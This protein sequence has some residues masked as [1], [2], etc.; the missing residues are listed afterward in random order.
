MRKRGRNVRSAVSTFA[1]AAGFAALLLLFAKA[2]RVGAQSQQSP[3]E[4]AS[5]AAAQTGLNAASDAP[6]PSFEVASIKLHVGD[7]MGARVPIG[8]GATD[9]SRWNASNMTAKDLV[10]EAYGLS[11]FQVTGGPDWA[12]SERFDISAKVDDAMATQL[13][14]LTRREQNQQMS[15]MLRSLLIDRFKLRVTQETK[16]APTYALVIAKGGP[17]LKE[18]TGG[19]GVGRFGVNNGQ[20]TATSTDISMSNFAGALSAQLAKP[21]VDQT[22]LTGKYDITWHYTMQ[23][24]LSADASAADTAGPTIFDA[25]QDQLGLKLESIK[26]PM[27]TITIEH[28]EEPTPN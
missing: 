11:Y 9:P 6:L 21:V 8:S 15:L 2:P 25:L 1:M 5:P 20:V 26:A 13:G 10:C 18:A 28:I 19:T 12:G 17:K 23:T 7:P 3:T 24:G 14:K 27:E 16:D 22:G 4:H